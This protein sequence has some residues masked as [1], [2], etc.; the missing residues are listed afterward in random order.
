MEE[1]LDLKDE[2]FKKLWESIH[3]RSRI[4]HHFYFVNV[5]IPFCDEVRKSVFVISNLGDFMFNQVWKS[6]P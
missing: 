5:N 1:V 2:D 4:L 3:L 6:I